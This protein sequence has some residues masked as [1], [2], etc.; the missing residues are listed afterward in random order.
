MGQRK[1][2]KW[3]ALFRVPSSFPRACLTALA[4]KRKEDMEGDKSLQ[5]EPI[6]K[7]KKR[8]N[9]RLSP[10]SEEIKESF[11]VSIVLIRA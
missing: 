3:S 10:V 1:V 5:L 7:E 6:D 9:I 4:E 2:P 8:G 11:I